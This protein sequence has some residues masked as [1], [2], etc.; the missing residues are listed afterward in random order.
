MVGIFNVGR[1]FGHKWEGLALRSPA[2]GL[3]IAKVFHRISPFTLTVRGTFGFPRVIISFSFGINLKNPKK[4]QCPCTGR[5]QY[6]W[7]CQNSGY[8]SIIK[9]PVRWSVCHPHL[10]DY[11]VKFLIIPFCWVH[12]FHCISNTPIF[13]YSVL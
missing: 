9:L 4:N 6:C 13:E 11:R 8:I 3:I 7:R 2:F 12:T 1:Y 5:I 10:C